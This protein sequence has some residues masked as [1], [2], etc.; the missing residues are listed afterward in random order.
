MLEYVVCPKRGEAKVSLQVCI[1]VCDSREDCE[2]YKEVPEADIQAV[3][4]KMNRLP[5]ARDDDVIVGDTEIVSTD[6]R[7][8][9]AG[10]KDT[11]EAGRLLQKAISIKNEIEGKFWEM[12]SILNGIFKN[13][14]YVDY[15]YHDWKD[16]CNEVLEMKWRT[17]TYL[18][19]IYVKFSGLGIE[20]SD[21]IGVGWG[22][23]KELLPIVKKENVR[24]WLQL[25]KEKKVSIAVLNHKVRH[26]LGKISEEDVNKLP[27]QLVFRLFGPQLQNVERTLELARRMTGSESRGYQ[28]EMICAEFRATY[29]AVEEDYTK[30]KS[31][32]EL[33][34]KVENLLGVAFKGETIDVQTGEVLREA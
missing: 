19:D 9:R 8:H 29:E 1:E 15:G 17:A 3:L 25:A 33:L 27:S 18:R 13:Q 21:C 23:L 22:K 6:D 28:L 2:E 4:A 32:T 34:R 16:F 31:A 5:V 30:A 20:S 12:G 10:D 7:K 14:Y 11:E 26:A 24:H